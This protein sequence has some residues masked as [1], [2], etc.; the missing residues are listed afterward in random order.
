MTAMTTRPIWSAGPPAAEPPDETGG[1]V[2]GGGPFPCNPG[3]A[4]GLGEAGRL[5]GGV[6]AGAAGIAPCVDFFR[7]APLN[8]EAIQSTTRRMRALARLTKP[9]SLRAGSDVD[10]CTATGMG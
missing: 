2:A 10:G 7:L 4:G 3:F 8:G 6:A 1:G 9:V 5:G